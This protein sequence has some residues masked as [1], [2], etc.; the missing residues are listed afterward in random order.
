MM[1]AANIKNTL[2][3]VITPSNNSAAGAPNTCPTDPAAVAIPKD[4]DLFSLEDARPTTAR[5]TPKPVPAMPKPT[6]IS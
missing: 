1:T 3:H 6:N 2:C 5:I 4:I